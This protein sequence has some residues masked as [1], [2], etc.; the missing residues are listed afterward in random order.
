MNAAT[1][2][3]SALAKDLASASGADFLNTAEQVIQQAAQ[4]VQSEA[5]TRAP[6]RSGAL[7]DSIAIT[8]VNRLTAVIA[9]Q[10]PYGVYQEFGTGSRW[11][12]PGSPYQIKAKPG[13]VLAFKVNGKMIYRRMVTHPGV[14]PRRFMRA[15]LEAALGPTLVGSL[16][17]A[18]ALAITKGPKA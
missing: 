16:A 18:G 12:F 13:K 3:L 15:G 9:P 14:R 17:D 1:A 5:R 6:V 10:V 11:E 2:D 7:R 8:Y 4:R